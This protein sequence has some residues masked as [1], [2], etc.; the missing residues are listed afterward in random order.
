MTHSY[1]P[2]KILRKWT[3]DIPGGELYELFVFD[4]ETVCSAV[5]RYAHSSGSAFSSWGEF[6]SGSLNDLVRQEMGPDFLM[7]ALAFVRGVSH[8]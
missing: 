5:G 8:A 1:T 7:E 3:L 6:L 4:D 2:P